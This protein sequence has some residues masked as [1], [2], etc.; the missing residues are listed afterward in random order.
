MLGHSLKT[1]LNSPGILLVF[2]L[3][4]WLSLFPINA[5]AFSYDDIIDK[6]SISI[7]V[8]RDHPPF[9]FQNNGK[10]TGIDVDIANHIASQLGVELEL[11]PITADESVDDDLRNAIW[12]GHIVTKQVADIM[13]HVPYDREMGLRNTQAVLFGPYFKEQIVTARNIEKLGKDA[14]IAHFRYEKISVELDSL[15]DLYLLGAFGGSIR[16]NV[17]HFRTN[18]EAGESAKKGDTAG[19]MGPRSQVEF[20]LIPNQERFDIGVIP[21]PGLY[22]S[23]WLIGAAVKH[24]YR[25][26]GYAVEDIIA[27]MVRD[28]SMAKIFKN[29][30]I[31]YMPPSLDYLTGAGQ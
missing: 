2:G 20:S 15:T 6:G 30:G 24:T 8:Y 18:T 11:I 16:S 17:V 21:T 4:V 3:L 25:Q 5:T 22:K 9:S 28:G 29:Y 13:L 14:N 12:K 19:M 31:S 23:E 1:R 26:L 7:A 27:T 10:Y